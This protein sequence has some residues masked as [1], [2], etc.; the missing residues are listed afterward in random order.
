MP[1]VPW[2]CSAGHVLTTST[3][4]QLSAEVVQILQSASQLAVTMAPLT[5][6]G[7]S[8]QDL[9][10]QHAVVSASTF[11]RAWQA[12]LDR[13]TSQSET[14]NLLSG[15]FLG[16]GLGAYL[17]QA[18]IQS[19]RAHPACPDSEVSGFMRLLRIPA[20]IDAAACSSPSSGVGR[21]SALEAGSQASADPQ[22]PPLP[23]HSNSQRAT[24]LS[25]LASHPHSLPAPGEYHFTLHSCTAWVNIQPAAS[26]T[27]YDEQHNVLTC[28]TGCKMVWLCRP[29]SL[30]QRA[31]RQGRDSTASVLKERCNAWPGTQL[32]DLV[33]PTA[34][35]LEIHGLTAQQSATKA[36]AAP[37]GYVA[38]DVR[39]HSVPGG[40]AA[41]LVRFERIQ[42]EQQSS[43]TREP[44]EIFVAEMVPG[45]SL[46]IPPG[47]WHCVQSDR[48]S[49]A[50]S[51]TAVCS[52]CAKRSVTGACSDVCTTDF[53]AVW[54]HGGGMSGGGFQ[55]PGPT[56]NFPMSDAEQKQHDRREGAAASSAVSFGLP[57]RSAV[58]AASAKHHKWGSGGFV[59]AAASPAV[60]HPPVRTCI[61]DA[62]NQAALDIAL[63]TARQ[64]S[65]AFLNCAFDRW[66]QS[67]QSACKAA[68][69]VGAGAQE[70]GSAKVSSVVQALDAWEVGSSV[71]IDRRHCEL[72]GCCSSDELLQVLCRMTAPKHINRCLLWM[73]RWDDDA[74]L[75][76]WRR[77][78]ALGDHN[79]QLKLQ[80]ALS[81]LDTA[82][83]NSQASA[84]RPTPA[85]A[86]TSHNGAISQ[87]LAERA[88]SARAAMARQ[89]LASALGVWLGSEGCPGAGSG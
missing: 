1:A 82:A 14:S 62:S 36:A 63:M 20:G 81:L 35:Q 47:W 50:L 9:Q 64:S 12:A 67:F 11:A 76:A 86:S 61:P 28:L 83:Q 24:A 29:S 22:P 3:P 70:S 85:H 74:C 48:G 25:S 84:Q 66:E 41:H 21:A 51:V 27:H 55:S 26:Q 33:P 18:V 23:P 13:S 32:W 17:A 68:T 4:S 57:T 89:L 75:Y 73:L 8:G 16:T 77:F 15:S 45:S 44:L 19:G 2:L 80:R 40:G 53:A 58:A 71:A 46:F 42:G 34:I 52:H 72:L 39:A 38:V 78:D 7:L 6:E 37:C 49:A 56:A 59:S 10:T 60:Q 5:A 54:C 88:S 79:A 31:P 87:R 43:T 65:S 69:G 30:L